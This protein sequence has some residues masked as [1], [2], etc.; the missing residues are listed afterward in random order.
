MKGM[1]TTG[2]AEATQTRR[3]ASSQAATQ[4]HTQQSLATTFLP[5]P[6][7]HVDQRRIRDFTTTSH[8]EVSASNQVTSQQVGTTRCAVLHDTARP[9]RHVSVPLW[10]CVFD[11]FLTD[12]RLFLTDTVFTRPFDTRFRHGCKLHRPNQC[13][14]RATLP[15]CAPAQLSC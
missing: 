2:N 7:P 14:V 15:L 9:C 10:S 3:Y 6:A 1:E 13:R 8:L 5:T 11:P 4:G 12:N